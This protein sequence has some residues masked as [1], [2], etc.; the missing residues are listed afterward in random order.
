[1]EFFLRHFHNRRQAARKFRR[2]RAKGIQAPFRADILPS[3]VNQQQGRWQAV[4]RKTFQAGANLVGRH[5]VIKRV[6]GAPAEPVN[7]RRN[8]L[9][10]EW[11]TSLVAL[12]QHPG[13]GRDQAHR[14]IAQSR[15]R[16]TQ[17]FR[18][19]RVRRSTGQQR[20][21]CLAALYPGPPVPVRRRHKQPPSAVAAFPEKKLA[22]SSGQIALMR[23]PCRTKPPRAI[24]LQ[25][26]KPFQA[27]YP[28][29]MRK[30]ASV[31]INLPEK[32][33]LSSGCGNPASSISPRNRHHILSFHIAPYRV[34]YVYSANLISTRL[35]PDGRITSPFV[36]MLTVRP[37]TLTFGANS[38]GR[39][40]TNPPSGRA[41]PFNV[42][43]A[44]WPV[45]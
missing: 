42:S 43:S 12:H 19:I 17:S 32:H 15:G 18:L 35:A 14:I 1:M 33:I 5:L 22:F 21:A 29:S 6:I 9:L 39:R 23:T 8:S 41:L 27:G 24:P 34:R 30:G 25:C 26:N 3:V 16:K 7:P 20:Q 11:T 10:A 37:S 13:Y 31:S 36:A 45:A 44:A 2:I 40:K 4:F 38:G 28:Q